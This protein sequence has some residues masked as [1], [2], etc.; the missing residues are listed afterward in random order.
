M[1]CATVWWW[2]CWLFS[3]RVQFSHRIVPGQAA[4]QFTST[5]NVAFFF[6]RNLLFLYMPE[7]MCGASDHRKDFMINHNE[8]DLHRPGTVALHCCRTSEFFESILENNFV[9]KKLKYMD[10]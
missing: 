10:I 2:W 9:L 5:S 3:F 7:L 4:K 6:A 8:S 1:N